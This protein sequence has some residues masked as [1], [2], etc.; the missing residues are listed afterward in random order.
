M[1]YDAARGAADDERSLLRWAREESRTLLTRN[2]RLIERRAGARGE[3]SALLLDSDRV[4]EQLRQVVAQCGLDARGTLS[5]CIRCNSVLESVTKD[6][7]RDRVPPY[8]YGTQQ[9]FTRCPSC[10]RVYWRGSHWRT[11]RAELSRVMEAAR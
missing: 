11:M 2:A 1:G 6:R 7:V 3:V 9:S 8:V 5:R 10:D 4:W